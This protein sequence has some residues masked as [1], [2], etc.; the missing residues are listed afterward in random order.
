MDL[1][2]SSITADILNYLSDGRLHNYQ[3]I[4]REVECSVSTVRR[5]VQSLSYRY[6]IDVIHGGEFG[7]G[8]LLDTKYIVNGKIMTN[9]KL[10]IIGKAL[11]LLQKSNDTSVD[12]YL[13]AELINDYRPP[14]NIK[15][16]DR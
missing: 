13:L 9:D 15:Q 7:G 1:R 6:P 14:K 12:E 4:A 11:E 16:E 2:S 10:Q 5:H 8:V 3:Q